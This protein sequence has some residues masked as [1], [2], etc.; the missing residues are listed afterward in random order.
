MFLDLFP[1][2]IF[3]LVH[4]KDAKQNFCHELR[5]LKTNTIERAKESGY[6]VFFTPNGIG[7]IKN[8]KGTL[9]RWDGNVTNLNAC[10]ADFDK[11]SKEEQM[12]TIRSMPIQPSI[13]VESKRGYHTYWLL[14]NTLCNAKNISLWRR[15]QTTI[16][17]KYGTDKACSNPSRL[18]RLPGSY[19]VKGEPF[20]VS[21][22][23]ISNKSYSLADIE[24]AFP[25]PPRPIYAPSSYKTSVQVLVPPIEALHEGERHPSLNRV[26]GS[27]Y[28]GRQRSDFQSI[29]FALKTW[30]SLSCINLKP[31]WEREV[32]GV[33]DWVESRES[34]S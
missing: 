2:H 29:R 33:C 20:K 1:G 12:K 23:E 10:F 5:Q 18:L 7:E 32:D 17:T 24:I 27:M 15:I 16:A 22:A 34:A 31:D 25:P 11:F 3:G 28:R 14:E 21:V 8:P 9:L 19:H 4:D 26:A 13:I 30:Y 6:G